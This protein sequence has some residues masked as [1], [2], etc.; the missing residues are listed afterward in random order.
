MD[1]GVIVV[2][3]GTVS[4]KDYWILRNSWGSDWGEEGYIRLERKINEKTAKCG[5]AKEPSYPIKKTVQN[6]GG[7]SH[8]ITIQEVCDQLYYS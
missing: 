5:I 3:Y 7:P 1:H 8:V 6:P 2:G 4:G